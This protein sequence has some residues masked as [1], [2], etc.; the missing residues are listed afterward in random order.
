VAGALGAAG[1]PIVMMGEIPHVGND[2]FVA[3]MF[4]PDPNTFL[5]LSPLGRAFGLSGPCPTFFGEV[6]ARR[7]E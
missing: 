5:R 2:R 1:C 6:L 4:E 7:A 3:A